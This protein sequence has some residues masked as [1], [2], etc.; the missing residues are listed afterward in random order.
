MPSLSDLVE[1]TDPDDP[2]RAVLEAILNS[3]LVLTLRDGSGVFQSTSSVIASSLGR[4]GNET[5]AEGRQFVAGQRFFD[6][7]GRELVRSDHPAQVVR[8]TGIPQRHR[9]IGLRAENGREVWLQMSYM[10]LEASPEGWSVLG[11]GALL[12]T[13]FR[14]PFERAEDHST[15][16]GH[17]LRFAIEIA[18]VRLPREELAARMRSV[19]DAIVPAPAS[20]LLMERRGSDGML[21]PVS[22]HQSDPLPRRFTLSPDAIGRWDRNT[23]VYQDDVRPSAVVGPRIAVEYD[24]PVRSLALVPVRSGRERIASIVMSSPEP[25]ALTLEQ[26]AALEA[27]AT[28]AGP[29]LIPSPEE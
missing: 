20:T 17:L 28:L 8:R 9:T 15:Y 22:S 12:P 4:G 23:T 13:G 25:Q 19:V 1:Q 18:G 3:G 27:L 21:S 16:E 24:Q 5:G 2:R 7:L 6:D 26:I 14:T 29:M 10:P 11:V